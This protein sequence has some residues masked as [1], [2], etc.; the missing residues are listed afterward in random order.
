MGVSYPLETYDAVNFRTMNLGYN[1]QAQYMLRTP[2]QLPWWADAGRSLQ[3]QKKDHFD[4]TRQIVYSAVENLM[5][6]YEFDYVYFCTQVLAFCL[7]LA[8]ELTERNVY[9][10]RYAKMFNHLLQLLVFFTTF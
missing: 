5:A 9:K 7:F 1:F 2:T 8:K 10:E 3:K 6:R 4:N